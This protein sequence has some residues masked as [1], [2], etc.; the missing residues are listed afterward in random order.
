MDASVRGRML[1]K[2]ADLIER[3]QDYLAVSSEYIKL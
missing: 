3:D 1:N 2:F